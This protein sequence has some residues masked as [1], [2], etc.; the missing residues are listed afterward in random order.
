VATEDVAFMCEQMG[1][2]TGIDLQQLVKAADFA[3]QIAPSAQ[4][5]KALGYIK[6][7]LQN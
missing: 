6:Q 7:F 1:F 4:G 3:M 5:G 2:S